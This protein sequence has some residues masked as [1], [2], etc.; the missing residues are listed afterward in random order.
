MHGVIDAS[1]VPR[2]TCRFLRHPARLKGRSL[3]VA[4]TLYRMN[5]SFVAFNAALT[6]AVQRIARGDTSSVKFRR[7]AQ[8]RMDERGF[9]HSNVL[10]CLRR[11]K[12]HG[13]EVRDGQLRANVVHRGMHIRVVIGGLDS[14][15]Q[16][17]TMLDSITVITVIGSDR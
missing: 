10:A 17:W 7:H 12:A 1:L 6:K 15:S 14:C 11:G 16:N 8:E 5:P 9:D 4:Y 3:A 2:L 13:P